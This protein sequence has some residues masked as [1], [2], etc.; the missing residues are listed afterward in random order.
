[1]RM[2][3]TN[4]NITSG[5]LQISDALRQIN[6]GTEDREHSSLHSSLRNAMVRP[7]GLINLLDQNLLSFVIELAIIICNCYL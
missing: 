2:N 5:I 3:F 4:A 6:D 7:Q 1:M